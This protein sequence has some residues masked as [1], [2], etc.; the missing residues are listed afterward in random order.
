MWS[1]NAGVLLKNAILLSAVVKITTDAETTVD[2][3]YKHS[4]AATQLFAYFISDA[5]YS[6]DIS[7]HG[8]WC[9]KLDPTAD[10]SVLGGPYTADGLDLIC[11]QWARA[12]HCSQESGANCETP[13]SSDDIYQLTYSN[14]SS[15]CPDNDNCLSETCQIDMFYVN[16]ILN[17]N[18]AGWTP[19]SCNNVATT[20][21]A[22]TTAELTTA[23]VAQAAEEAALS[24]NTG[25][26]SVHTCVQFETTPMPTQLEILCS[27]TPM[28][29]VFVVDGS[30]SVAA[31]NFE[32]QIEFVKAVVSN[33]TV[34]TDQTR[35][36]MVQFSSFPATEFG[37][38][39]DEDQLLGKLDNVTQLIGGTNTGAA[40]TYAYDNIIIGNKRDNARI[41]VLVLTDG[42][43][44]DDVETPSDTL[45]GHGVYMFAAGWQQANEVQ[46][47]AIAN[48][49]V[50]D[51][52]Y[53]GATVDDLLAVT[54]DLTTVICS[55]PVS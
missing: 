38:L 39:T 45:R 50:E 37:F 12:R 55:Q 14:S 2:I 24:S 19:S 18:R 54:D 30:G 17:F 53:Q 49:P 16:E 29:L 43:S 36:A 7:S 13:P 10:Q 48:E 11:K 4:D 52:V 40:I 35:I 27:T 8:C 23:L 44:F 6:S 51:F 47:Q 46:L 21:A 20:Q 22:V 25:A 41:C 5:S 9:A 32:K 1:K 15:Q 42:F 26:T 34:G 31:E 33:M 3:Y 28:D